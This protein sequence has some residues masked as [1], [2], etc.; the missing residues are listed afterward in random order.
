MIFRLNDEIKLLIM[1]VYFNLYFDR[2]VNIYLVRLVQIEILVCIGIYKGK[3]KGY[4]YEYID[5]Q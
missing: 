4:V 2:Y 1:C 3:I 5:K